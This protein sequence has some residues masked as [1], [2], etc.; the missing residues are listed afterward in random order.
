[1][2]CRHQDPFGKFCGAQKAQP[3]KDVAD[4]D[5]EGMP[6][7]WDYIEP[8]LTDNHTV[9]SIDAVDSVGQLCPLLTEDQ[10]FPALQGNC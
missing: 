8:S 9:S 6:N 10:C 4:S 2:E 5:P 1:M 3:A 7:P